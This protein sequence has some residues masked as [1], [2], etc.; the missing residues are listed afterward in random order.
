MQELDAKLASAAV[1][2]T[3]GGWELG[4]ARRTI[5]EEEAL[6]MFGGEGSTSIP[7]SCY[8]RGAWVRKWNQYWK[9]L[10][11]KHEDA[12][13]SAWFVMFDIAN[14]YDSV[15]LGRL[16]TSVR[17]ISGGAHFAINVLFHLLS[18][19][20]RALSLYSPSSKGLPMDV[21]GD[22]SRLLANFFLTGFDRSFREGVVSE[23]G[24]YMRF[25]DDMVV[26]GESEEDCQRFVY[27]AAQQ[28]HCLGLNINVAKVRYCSKKEFEQF[29]GFVIMDRFESGDII[30]ALGLLKTAIEADKYG[31]KSMALKR[32]LTL[33]GKLDRDGEGKWWRRWVREMAIRENLALHLSREQLLSLIGLYDEPRIGIESLQRTFLDQPFSQPKAIFLRAIEQLRSGND[34]I[35]DLCDSVVD[36][37][38]RLGDPVL[39]ICASHVA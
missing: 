5:E 19:W 2:E 36:S 8:N 13:D 31:R 21:V 10:A 15:D 37:I 38:Q 24:H 30:G 22:C 33:A 11:A 26:R 17:A 16:E 1:P 35:R 32:A 9:L 3:F 27:E 28:L 14:F 25:A 18:G 39:S 29:W 7:L 6:R 23:G 34:E 20:N 12:D 4:S